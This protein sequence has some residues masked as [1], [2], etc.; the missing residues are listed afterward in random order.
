MPDGV[1]LKVKLEEID[2][3]LGLGTA[4]THVWGYNFPD[5]STP[6]PNDYLGATYPGPT[7][8]AKKDRRLAV[9]WENNLPKNHLLPVDTTLHWAFS[10]NGLI[11][12]DGVPVMTHLH[13]GHTESASDGLPEA[14][15]TL[16]YKKKGAYYVK[17]DHLYDNTQEGATLWYHDHA[18]GITRLNVYA[19]LAG[20][21][22]LRDDNELGLIEEGILPAE[23]YEY[24]IVIQD[25]MFRS[26]G[27]LIFPAFC[28][29]P[30]AA[31][32][33]VGDFVTCA[34]PPAD[35][36]PG[37][38]NFPT[39]IAEFFGNI[40]LVNGT[41]WPVLNVEP[42]K[43]RLRLLNGSDSRFY[44]LQLGG[45]TLGAEDLTFL[46]IG[47]DVGFLNETVELDYFVL[48]PGER[49]DVVVDFADLPSGNPSAPEVILK[50]F[51]PDEPF[52][53]LPV[54]TPADPL[55]TG[56]IMKFV[57]DQPLDANVPE[58]TVEAGDTDLRDGPFAVDETTDTVR[59][60]ALFEEEDSF[61]RLRPQL[62]T[63][64]DGSLLW[65][66]AIT[67]NPGLFDVEE[68]WIH[69]ATADA[70]PI[71]LHLVAFEI[72]GRTDFEYELI[73]LG[74]D[75]IEGGTKH[76]INILNDPPLT[77]SDLEAPPPNEQGPK[78]TVQAFPGDPDAEPKTGQVT[79]VKAKYDRQGR[80][81]WHCHILSH[82]DHEMMRPYFIGQIPPGPP[83]MPGPPM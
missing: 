39:A 43:Y 62:G 10:H 28:S 54:D 30:G 69:N 68:W 53:G 58:A 19:G 29:D 38:A 23:D 35:D 52:G 72:L 46:Q 48:G 57:V 76:G 17:K 15:D 3:D 64:A 78:D 25:R 74:E 71:H 2:Q 11:A 66:E 40:I 67:E 22:L 65:D 6:N 79:V 24:E 59:E 16:G 5:L 33:L 77:L 32:E 45:N 83:P 55:S 20:F 60:L 21:Y 56:L 9:R 47:S 80:Y 1:Y 50:N 49:A 31:G 8:V 14:W 13:G 51:G 63:V 18:L 82:E 42:R 4:D 12:D 41:P 61:G 75:P 34:S 70:H 26:D 7:I 44:V 36:E 37:G 27:S 73:D 81:V